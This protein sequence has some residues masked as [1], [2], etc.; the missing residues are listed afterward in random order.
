MA[1]STPTSDSSQVPPRPAGLAPQ[2]GGGTIR[3]S[4]MAGAGAVL[5]ALVALIMAMGLLAYRSH[6]P[7]PVPAQGQ[8]AAGGG[9]M[10][11]ELVE[12]VVP[13]NVSD[14]GGI[15]VGQPSAPVT[16]DIYFDFHCPACGKFEQYFQPVFAPF[17]ADGTLK[18]Q[19]HPVSI[20]DRASGGARYSTRAANTAYCLA[21]AEPDKAEQFIQTLLNSQERLPQKGFSDEELVA[22]AASAG[23]KADLSSCMADESFAPFAQVQLRESGISGTPTLFLNGSQVGNQEDSDSVPMSPAAVE[24]EIMELANS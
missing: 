12:V 6:S 22:F 4:T 17:V 10:P 3:W 7:E 19:Y 13:R 2:G 1:D 23:A 16:A 5:L 18:V 15:V 24:A 14:N 11:E 8:P 20:L 9:E 21:E